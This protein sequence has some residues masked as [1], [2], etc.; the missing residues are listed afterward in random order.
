MEGLSLPLCVAVRS[1]VH[2]Q[3][4]AQFAGLDRVTRGQCGRHSKDSRV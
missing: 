1:L 4:Q 3:D 2:Q